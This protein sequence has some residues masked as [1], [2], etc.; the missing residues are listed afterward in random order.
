MN[1]K[2]LDQIPINVLKPCGP[3]FFGTTE[4]LIN[5]YANLSK[6]E[7]LIIDL[8]DVTSIDLTG[9]FVLE[10]LIDGSKDNN[11]KV[12]VINAL[13]KVK[14]VLQKVN[15]IDNIGKD[16]YKDSEKSIIEI[17]SNKYTS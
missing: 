2:E 17:I 11:I 15:F 5:L 14:K 6:H 1:K 7:M 13:P 9:V 3:L 12:F 4:S 8:A 16:Y 10:D